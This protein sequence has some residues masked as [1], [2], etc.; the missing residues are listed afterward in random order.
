MV[1]EKKIKSIDDDFEKHPNKFYNLKKQLEEEAGFKEKAPESIEDKLKTFE[2]YHH[3]EHKFQER[4]T[5]DLGVI[6]NGGHP[7]HE[8]GAKYH[9]L[10][11][12]YNILEKDTDKLE[13]EEDI[14]KVLSP[15]IDDFLKHTSY[16]QFK[17]LEEDLKKGKPDGTSYTEEEIFKFK[18]TFFDRMISAGA[19]KQEGG[20]IGS[21]LDLSYNLKGKTRVEIEQEVDKLS[22]DTILGSASHTENRIMD[23][24]FRLEDAPKIKKYFMGQLENRGLQ[25]KETIAHLSHT[26]LLNKY[27]GLLRDE[28]K[29]EYVKLEK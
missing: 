16:E 20:K 10:N 11:K 9:A 29:E 19:G 2:Y 7:S 12:L 8:K 17:E 6:V 14:R 13:K 1:E 4:F 25:P 26:G 22:A 24:Y 23:H 5:K 15:F 3:P 28:A 27:A 18:A 21:V